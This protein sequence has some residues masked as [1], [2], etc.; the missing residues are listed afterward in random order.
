MLNFELCSLARQYIM[1]GL[2]LKSSLPRFC[3][4]TVE[5]NQSYKINLSDEALGTRL[6][7]VCLHV[8]LVYVASWY[9]AYP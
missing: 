3:L 1:C 7:Y 2:I 9:C 5:K 6:H 4:L 8:L